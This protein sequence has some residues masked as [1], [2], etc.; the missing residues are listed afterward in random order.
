MEDA[1]DIYTR[2][3]NAKV[4]RLCFDE[5]PCQLVGE[6][7]MPMAM[8]P[9]HA[10]KQDDEYERLGVCSV[11]MAYDIDRGQRYLQVR[12][13]R[14]KHDYAQFMAWL[15]TTYYADV[16]KVQVVQ[17]NLN[18]HTY[19]AFYETFAAPQAHQLK[20]KFEFHFTPK[21]A[22]WLNMV[23]I[24]LSAF[25]RQCADQ[26]FSSQTAFEQ[27]ASTWASQRNQASVRIAWTFTRT[28]AREKL[29][30]HYS[31]VNPNN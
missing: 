4:A 12:E 5:R 17:D 14:T 6:V 18:T 20:Q 26:R 27:E 30:R 10:R 7:L 8:Q 19:G 24:E 21:H 3:F 13:R 22:S 1:L 9:G 28:K 15:A 16:P 23:E 29:K 11:L 2:P 31:N 25:A